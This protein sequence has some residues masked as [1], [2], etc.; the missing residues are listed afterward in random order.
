M[1]RFR[2]RPVQ[3]LDV[4]G[5][6]V[7]LPAIRLAVLIRG[8]RESALCQAKDEV[9]RERAPRRRVILS[10]AFVPRALQELLVPPIDCTR[11]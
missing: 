9:P 1:A 4:A 11:G 10:L 5:G 8:E 6:A 7:A 2:A 3:L